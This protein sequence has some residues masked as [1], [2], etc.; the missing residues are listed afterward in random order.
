MTAATHHWKG[1]FFGVILLLESHSLFD[2]LKACVDTPMNQKRLPRPPRNFTKDGSWK[3]GRTVVTVLSYVIIIVA[4]FS[5]I[6]LHHLQFHLHH[7]RAEGDDNNRYW[8]VPSA[9]PQ[10]NHG[11]TDIF[12]VTTNPPSP[13]RFYE[14]VDNITKVHEKRDFYYTAFTDASRIIYNETH[15]FHPQRKCE[16]TCCTETVAISLDQ[17]D[18]HIKNTLDG[19]DMADTYLQHLPN[20]K[21]IH[22]FGT[23]ITPDLLP[24][25]Q[26]GTIIHIDTHYDLL[27]YFFHGLRPNISVPYVLITS[28]SDQ[29][30]PPAGLE[31]LLSNDNLLLKWFGINPSTKGLPTAQNQKFHGMPLGLSKLHDQ[32]R[33]IHQLCQSISKQ[34]VVDTISLDECDL[35]DNNYYCCRW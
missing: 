6:S 9:M 4:L 15:F 8:Y 18:R 26:P 12:A 31:G 13:K 16:L 11:D 17:D 30:S 24:C 5:L 25:L 3:N 28:K 14:L 35:Y 34:G 33:I 27:H 1:R 7:S 23:I 19:T 2:I 22:Y 32:N 29:V 20:S 21:W 10:V